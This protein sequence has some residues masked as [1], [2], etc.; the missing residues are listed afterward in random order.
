MVV[1]ILQPGGTKSVERIIS[2]KKHAI[3]RETCSEG[4]LLKREEGMEDTSIIIIIR[5]IVMIDFYVMYANECFHMYL[6][7][8]IFSIIL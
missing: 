8:I 1:I 5:I 7:F 2:D 4:P 6:L 3:L